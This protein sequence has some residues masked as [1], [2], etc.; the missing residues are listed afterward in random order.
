M[1]AAFSA[2]GKLANLHYAHRLVAA[3]SGFLVLA[4]AIEAWRLRPR[5]AI[6][7][8]AV[9]A[10]VILYIAQVF[11]GASNIWF[12]L[13]S[14]VRIAHLAIASAAWATLVFLSIWAYL[15]QAR[16]AERTQ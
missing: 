11:I 13:A 5:E 15:G 16:Q 6:I 7:L 1:T 12:S 3:A 10:V 9:V 2:G 8:A 4:V 14:S